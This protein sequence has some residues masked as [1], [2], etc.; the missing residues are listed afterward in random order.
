MC[1]RETV[2]L[3]IGH[4]LVGHVRV[5]QQAEDVIGRLCEVSCRRKDLLFRVAQDMCFFAENII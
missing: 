5:V 1:Y 4:G 2:A 3:D